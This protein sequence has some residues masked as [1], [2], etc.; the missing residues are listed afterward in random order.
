MARDLNK[1][2]L[3]GRLGIDPEMRYTPTGS[4]VTT[5][6]VAVGRQW[7]DSNG[8]N[9]EETEWFSVVAWNKLAEICN[10]YLTKGTR[11][12]IEGRLQTRSWEDQQTGQT[13]YKTEVI[14][15]DMIILDSREGRAP[16]EVDDYGAP[17][18]DA[19]RSSRGAVP[20]PPPDIG[21][22]DIPF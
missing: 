16:R 12:Y 4:A 14:A 6:R 10:Q 19:S 18:R 21:D 20:P 11:V 2:M 1:V 9:R 22:E 7:R 17:P 13:R 5:F 15:S 3:I 8:D